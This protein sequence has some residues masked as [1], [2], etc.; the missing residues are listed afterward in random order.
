MAYTTQHLSGHR[1]SWKSTLLGTAALVALASISEIKPARAVIVETAAV[2]VLI[3]HFGNIAGGLIDK[4]RDSGDFLVWRLG[5]QLQG[6]IDAWKKANSELLNES[7]EKLDRRAQDFFRNVDSEVEKVRDEKNLTFE[8]VERLTGEWSGIISQT[9]I[10]SSD[11]SVLNYSPRVLVPDGGRSVPL[12][13]TGPNLAAANATIDLG[14]ARSVKPAAPLGHQVQFSLN[15][16]DF[17]FPEDESAT[18][19]LPMKYRT[20]L[21]KWYN[22]TTWFSLGRTTSDL[23]IVLLPKRLAKYD[24]HTRVQVDLKKSET[25]VVNL[26]KFQGRN[27]RIARAVAAPDSALGWRIDLTRRSEIHLVPGGGDHGRCEGIEDSSVTENGLTMFARVDNRD[28]WMGTKDAWVDCSISLPIYRMES[29]EQDGPKRS[30][31]LSWTKD[32]TFELPPNLKSIH[33]NVATFDRRSR[34]FTGAGF[35]RFFELRSEGGLL[36]FRP[37]P[38]KDL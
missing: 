26:G 34:M 14:S 12:V 29:Q 18:V 15:R 7:F 38:P 19:N 5:I 35:D 33:V 16:S 30:G 22:P 28:H 25:R 8:Q 20:R 10:G 3:N 24:V 1:R 27:S 6:L 23:G 11:P 32:E 37:R 17:V 21:F 4:G 9:V 36:I 2:S 13:A 31:E